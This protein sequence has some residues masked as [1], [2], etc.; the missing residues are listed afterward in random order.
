[1][2]NVRF[3]HVQMLRDVRNGNVLQ[4]VRVNKILHGAPDFID[5]RLFR[6][7]LLYAGLMQQQQQAADQMCLH[8][9]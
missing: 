2:R 5:C 3:S 1:M 6:C 7:V 9:L 4:I 8:F